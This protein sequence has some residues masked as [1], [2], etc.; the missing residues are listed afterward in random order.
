MTFYYICG[1]ENSPYND[2]YIIITAP[3]KEIAD[4]L[5][6]SRFP[7][8]TY[9]SVINEDKIKR[10]TEL[11]GYKPIIHESIGIF[12]EQNPVIMPALKSMIKNGIYMKGN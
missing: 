6:K 7:N 8:N 9:S 12:C 1:G 3:N 5:F 11:T 10:H 4:I 2:G